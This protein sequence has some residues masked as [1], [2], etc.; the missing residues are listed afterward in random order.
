MSPPGTIIKRQPGLRMSQPR[1]HPRRCSISLPRLYSRSR[2]EST[3]RR[4]CPPAI[5]ET[6][7]EVLEELDLPGREE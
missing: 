1:G 6:V 4:F 2:V 3:S 7:P 5:R